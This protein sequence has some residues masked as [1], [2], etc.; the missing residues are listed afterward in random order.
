MRKLTL[1]VFVLLIICLTLTNCRTHPKVIRKEVK[2]MGDSDEKYRNLLVIAKE[3]EQDAVNIDSLLKKPESLRHK[4]LIK[5]RLHLTHESYMKLVV[6]QQYIDSLNCDRLIQ[7][8]KEYG[9]PSKKAVGFFNHFDITVMI[10]HFQKY[11]KDL[12]P[13]LKQACLNGDLKP[14]DFARYYDK[15]CLVNKLEILYATEWLHPS[16]CIENLEK[17]NQARMEIG[18][19]PVEQREK[20][21]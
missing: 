16:K 11:E 21:R 4:D 2:A 20:C 19:K 18:L 14:I 5:K 3:S 1:Q 6:Q 15:Y 13:I 8:T 10:L 12:T 7:I 17:T 9:F